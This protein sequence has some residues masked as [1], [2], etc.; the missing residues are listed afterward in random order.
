VF[1]SYT[2]EI[3]PYWEELSKRKDAKG[4]K[5]TTADYARL[6]GKD[7]MTGLLDLLDLNP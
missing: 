7:L 5:M 4:D 6:L 2:L 3:L 1:H